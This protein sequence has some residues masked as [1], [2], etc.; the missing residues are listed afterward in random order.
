MSHMEVEDPFEYEEDVGLRMIEIFENRLTDM[1][2]FNC[3]VKLHW[4]KI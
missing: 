2:F 4:G 3:L 1:D